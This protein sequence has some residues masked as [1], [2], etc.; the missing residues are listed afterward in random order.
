MSISL[1]PSDQEMSGFYKRT[2]WYVILTPTLAFCSVFFHW[3]TLGQP[4]PLGDH[5]VRMFWDATMTMH[6]SLLVVCMALLSRHVFMTPKVEASWFFPVL[7]DRA[8]RQIVHCGFSGTVLLDIAA[9][10]DGLDMTTTVIATCYLGV[11]ILATHCVI[12]SFLL[13]L[14]CS[15]GFNRP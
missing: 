2:L 6:W 4:L 7:L 1:F 8:R 9:V 11:V 13:V 14:R 10:W 15:F 12:T 3:W 5:I